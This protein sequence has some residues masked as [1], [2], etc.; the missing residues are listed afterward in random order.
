MMN[1]IIA[2]VGLALTA[3]VFALVIGKEAPAIAFLL[4]L[5]AGI[6]ILYFAVQGVRE[7]LDALYSALQ[8]AGLDSGD[9]LPALKAVGIAVLV[10]IAAA[11]CRDAG[12]SSLAAKLEIAGAAA[13]MAVTLPLFTQ[14]LSLVQSMLT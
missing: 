13:A 3:S 4:T 12:Q 1:G 8:A 6:L 11:L 5:A 7:M 2:A 9:Y 10:R 14:V